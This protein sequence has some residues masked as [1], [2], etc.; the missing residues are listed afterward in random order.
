[1]QTNRLQRWGGAA[2]VFEAAAYALGIGLGFT[3][4]APF[5]TGALDAT[6]TVAFFQQHRTVLYLW[7]QVI[8]VFFGVALVVLA[9]ALHRR[10]GDAAPDLMRI[11]TAFGL[12][13]AALVL[14]AGMV[15]NVGTGVVM[16]LYDLDPGR[17]GAAWQAIAVVQN[18]L[19]GGNELVGGLWTLLVSWAG[20]RSGHL[21]RALNALGAAVGVAGLVTLVPGWQDAGAVFGL[22]QLV[23]FAWLGA[24]LLRARASVPGRSV[25]AAEGVS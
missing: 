24:D 12:I 10:L 22:G 19:G 2:A 8:L 3:V 23:W 13:W 14:A 5:M 6:E 7:N 11:A 16:D 18:G 21:P 9:L 20:W 4:L 1:M 17:A 25:V 15:F